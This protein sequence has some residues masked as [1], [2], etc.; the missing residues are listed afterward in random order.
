MPFTIRP[1]VVTKEIDLTTVLLAMENKGISID[2]QYAVETTQK[3]QDR[4]EELSKKIFGLVGE[5][6]INTT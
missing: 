3:L 4:K 5:F 2:T 6:N 1:G